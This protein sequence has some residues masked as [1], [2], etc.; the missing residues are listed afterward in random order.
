MM[1]IKKYF[2]FRNLTL[3]FRIIVIYF[4]ATSKVIYSSSL[5]YPLNS[6]NVS[7][8]L[9]QN[10][11]LLKMKYK[12]SVCEIKNLILCFF[13]FSLSRV[14]FLPSLARK[15]KNEKIFMIV[16]W[17][18]PPLTDVK[19]LRLTHNNSKLNSSVFALISKTFKK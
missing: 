18:K 13:M 8:I 7:S 16:P 19:S 17:W 2:E 5:P 14:H 15:G 6:F 9:Q 11:A 10:H 4:F 12:K 1:S 3:S